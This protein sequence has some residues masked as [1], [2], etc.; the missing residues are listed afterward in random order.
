MSPELIFGIVLVLVGGGILWYFFRHIGDQPEEPKNYIVFHTINGERVAIL[1]M[2]DPPYAGDDY[3]INKAFSE[4][5]RIL[6]NDPKVPGQ[7]FLL[8]WD[9]YTDF[10]KATRIEHG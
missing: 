4:A 6:Y 10:R 9:A 3:A 8:A 1:H 7:D 5:M 2:S